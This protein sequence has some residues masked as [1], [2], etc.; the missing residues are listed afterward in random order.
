MIEINVYYKKWYST[1]KKPKVFVKN[2]IMSS[3]I[4]LN[5]H[6]YKPLISIVL[7]NNI[8]LQQL[9]YEYRNKNKPTNVLSFQYDKLSKQCNL[10]EIFIS[11][12][13]LIEES[14]ELN[15]PIEHH[16]C[17]MLIHGL[18]HIL[19]YNHEEPLMQYIMESI[20]IKLLDKLGIKNPYVSRETQFK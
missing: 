20:E 18:L 6:E 16:T 19:E 3:L 17:H 14:I 9:N 12:D 11:L 1:I 13:T 15:I 7:A 2:V 8:L 10:G 4:D 5:I